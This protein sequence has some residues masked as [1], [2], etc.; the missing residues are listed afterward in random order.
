[1]AQFDVHRNPNS[2]TAKRIPFLVNV[3][4]DLLDGL[5]TRVVVPLARPDVIGNK[6]AHYLNPM[7]EV[8]GKTVVMLTP[9]MAGVPVKHLGQLVGNLMDRRV[10]IVRALD[11]VLSGV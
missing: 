8:S 5:A 4:S 6:P 9:E 3:Q 7:F 1:M 10:D 2:A 11:V